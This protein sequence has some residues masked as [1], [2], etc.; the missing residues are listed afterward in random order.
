MC[1]RALCPGEL[2]W[3][4]FKKVG[5]I[6]SWKRA[7]AEGKGQ[8]GGRGKKRKILRYGERAERFGE[9]EAVAVLSDGGHMARY[10]VPNESKFG[11]G[12][13]G[14][15]TRGPVCPMRP[16]DAPA[17]HSTGVHRVHRTEKRCA[18]AV[19]GRVR[20]TRR[21]GVVTAYGSWREN[22]VALRGF[23]YSKS[24]GRANGG[25]SKQLAVRAR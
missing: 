17:L 10:R 12:M 5:I 25:G 14:T 13:N 2:F 22:A 19:C 18:A 1:L 24:K 6:R 8:G 23:C 20:D 3:R 4:C 15:R 7:E 11:N 21:Y 16:E 9:N